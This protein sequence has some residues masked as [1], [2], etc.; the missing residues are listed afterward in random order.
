M[1]VDRVD[2]SK[3]V[4]WAVG[5][6]QRRTCGCWI[7]LD[8]RIHVVLRIHRVVPTH[9][10]VKEG[11]H[12]VIRVEHHPYVLS[13]SILYNHS[14][15]HQPSL[16]TRSSTI[17]HHIIN[18]HIIYLAGPSNKL[19]EQCFLLFGKA[20]QNVPEEC[21]LRIRTSIAMIIR[22]CSQ[23]IEIDI[24]EATDQQL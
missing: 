13:S 11:S 2:W 17:N 12:V 4:Q 8:H 19:Q 24:R 7:S 1:Q 21:D 15:H 20:L 16:V 10:A 23:I 3:Y 14:S 5:G 6:I 18:N 22:V 9:Y